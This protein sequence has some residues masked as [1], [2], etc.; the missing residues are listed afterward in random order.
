[1][2]PPTSGESAGALSIE[3][4]RQRQLGRATALSAGGTIVSRVSGLLRLVVIAYALGS[5][6]LADAFNLSNNTP[7]MIHDLVLGGVLAATFVPVFVERLTHATREEAMDSISAVLTVAGMML[8][9]ATV[10]FILLAPAIIDLYTFGLKNLAERAVAVELLRFFAPQ[11]LFYGAISLMTAVLATQDRFAAAGIVPVINNVVGIIV[12]ASFA[13]LAHTADAA[14]ASSHQGLIMLL[15][16]GTT[17]AVGLQAFALVPAL[18]RCGVRLR[19]RFHPGDPAVSMIL[20]MS[21]WTFAF[22]VANQVAVFV[23]MALATHLGAVSVYTYAFT[24][25]QFPFAIAATSIIA[26]AT[27][28]IA[29]AYTKRDTALV[30]ATFG[31]AVAQVLTVILPSMVGYLLLARPAMTLVLQH[32]NLGASGAQLTGAVLILFA[33][34]LPGFCVFFLATRTFQ[35]MRDTRTTFALYLF[36]NALNIAI[37]IALYHRLGAQGLALS[38]SIAYTLSALGAVYL[39]RERLGTIGGRSVVRSSVRALVL[40]LLMAVVVALLVAVIGTGTGISG[41]LRLV[42]AITAG[43]GTYVFGA[44]VAGVLGKRRSRQRQLRRRR[45]AKRQ[46][47]IPIAN[48]QRGEARENR[49]GNRQLKRLTSIRLRS[50]GRHFRASRRPPRR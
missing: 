36:E 12:L 1:M 38:Y 5:S 26:V 39:L 41:W 23:I 31:K 22:V 40:S 11:L 17:L 24:F 15:G 34:G 45:P 30:G 42:V 4:S 44:G 9:I 50:R 43:I 2:T 14:T 13:A 8:V 27:P 20:S 18:R 35:A 7:N 49:S 28:Q 10:A 25:F 33:L 37:A 47:V 3:R 21:G 46:T 48:Y 19:F 16:I 29:R 32:G 6:S